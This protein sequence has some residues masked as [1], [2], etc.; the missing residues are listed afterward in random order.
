M[1]VRPKAQKQC[2]LFALIAARDNRT[3]LAC[4]VVAEGLCLLNRQ[5]DTV[6]PELPRCPGTGQGYCVPDTVAIHIRQGWVVI[7]QRSHNHILAS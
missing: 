7:T 1:G 2:L 4:G 5:D 6:D 3:L